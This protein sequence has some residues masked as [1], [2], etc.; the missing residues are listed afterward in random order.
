M[1]EKL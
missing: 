1:C